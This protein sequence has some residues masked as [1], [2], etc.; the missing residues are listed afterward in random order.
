MTAFSLLTRR[1]F[2]SASAGLAGLLVAGSRLGLAQGAPK[3]GGRLVVAAD[4]EPKNLNPAIVASNGVFYVA[5]K[6]IEPLAEMTDEGPLRPVLATSWEAAADGKSFA[7]KLR[8]GVKWHDGQPFSSADVAFSAMQVWK[9]LQN[10]GRVVFANLEAVDTP[11]AETA[12]L[13][14]SQ[15]TP[16]QLIENA[17]PA[18]TSVLPKHL[19]D[20]TDIANNPHNVE[21]VGTGPFRFV[22]HKPGELYRLQRNP[23]YWEAGHPHLDEIVY[24]VLPDAAAK[25][26]ALETN[27]IQLTAFSAVP[28][29]DLARLAAIDGIEVVRQGYDGITYQVTLEINHRRKEF[30]DARVRQAL[31][32][33]IDPAFIVNNIFLGYAEAAQGPVPQS[34]KAMFATDLPAYAYDPKQA[35]SLLDEAGYPRDG[36]GV[37]F[38]V[39]LL[40]APWFQQTR[41]TGDYVRQALRQIGIEATIVNNDPGAHLKAVYTDHA[42]DLAIGS[43]VYRNDPAISTTVLYQG[44]LPDG[45]PFSNQYGYDD[46]TVNKIIADAA[47]TIDPAARIELYRT[48]QHEA[49]KQ[50]PLLHLVNFT[51]ITVARSSVRNVG[52]NP[53]W[54]TSSWYDTWLD[55]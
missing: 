48:F 10:L 27:D 26:A 29:S 17:L 49:M 4:T 1:W 36:S 22:E 6:V 38:A 12:V 30:Q 37:R 39:N 28:L 44:G 45:V 5:S 53:R 54:A 31:K 19:Y 46:P 24:R 34:D 11:D 32:H 35:E 2:L 13:R 25:A 18:L 14:F 43:P 40:P 23:D 50:L 47:V 42:F 41:Q 8:P 55:A 21:L 52:N 9:P 7:F 51:F 33:A 20:G 15:P 16:G 3:S